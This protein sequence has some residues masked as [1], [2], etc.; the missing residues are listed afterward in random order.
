MTETSK[1]NRTVEEQGRE[2][3]AL[4]RFDE[5]GGKLNRWLGKLFGRKDMATQGRTQEIKGKGE[6]GI[7]EVERKAGETLKHPEGDTL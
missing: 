7:G 1:E 5:A 2:K 4:G 3:A 6:K